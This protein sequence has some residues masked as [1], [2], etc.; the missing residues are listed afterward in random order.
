[1]IVGVDLDNTVASYDEVFARLAASAGMVDAGF[2]G[3]KHELR[4]R[5]RALAGEAAW[6]KLQAQVYGPAMHEAAVFDGFERFAQRCRELDVPL[7]LVSHK[8]EFA[9]ADANGVNL[10]SAARQWIGQRLGESTFATIHFED[11][12]A[13][14]LA[15]IAALGCTHFIDDLV[16]VLA[17]PAFPPA[18]R[19]LFDPL[20]R[21]TAPPGVERFASWAAL[22]SRLE[23]EHRVWTSTS[24]LA[25]E[26]LLRLL[27][28]G[29][30]GNNR[31]FRAETPTRALALKHFGVPDERERARRESAALELAGG[32]GLPVPKLAGIDRA[33]GVVLAE[34]ID[35]E[36]PGESAQPGDVEQMLAFAGAL[37]RL[38]LDP[39][40]ADLPEAAEAGLSL[41]AIW[42]QIDARIAR[43]R[44][45]GGDLDGLL[46]DVAGLLERQRERVG[47]RRDA[48]AVLEPAKRTLSP[49]DFGLHNARRRADGRLVFLD[50]EYFGWDDPVKLT[51]D[52][53]LHPGM[54]LRVADI[55]EWL[56]GAH[57]LF[58]R[59]PDF[60]A[61]L[62]DALPTYAL[63]WSVIVLNEF[64]PEVWA[65][66]SAARPGRDWAAVKSEQRAKALQ[67]IER[68]RHGEFE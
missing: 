5:V 60:A 2:S 50:F 22:R 11:D 61:R 23:D 17:E 42:D 28:A 30:G 33:A 65:R 14:K 44:V 48:F 52:V 24:Q 54:A 18:A 40:A 45:C 8:S 68:V 43:L 56:A 67:L 37:D 41:G 13:A 35:G 3:G 21:Q 59:D 38:R 20:E 63:K 19:W 32:H 51:A 62:G 53:A 9:A 1:M 26:P 25:G 49:S 31:L 7:F 47:R 57:R 55:K 39:A 36:A 15:R 16:E 27:P 29:G 66:R 4:E 12:R 46:D 64:R 58:G 34:W 6:T 10:R